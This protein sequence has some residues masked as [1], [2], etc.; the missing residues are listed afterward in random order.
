MDDVMRLISKIA[1]AVLALSGCTAGAH[2]SSP[3]EGTT[4]RLHLRD[5]KSGSPISGRVGFFRGGENL[6]FKQWKGFTGWSTQR[7]AWLDGGGEVSWTVSADS[8]II[9]PPGQ[10]RLVVNHGTEY[11]PFVEQI[12]LTEGDPQDIEVRMQRWID[13]SRMGWHSADFHLHIARFSPRHDSAL[14]DLMRSEGLDAAALVD[15]A[16]RTTGEK[17]SPHWGGWMWRRE[18]LEDAVTSPLLFMAQHWAMA[19]SACEL[20]LFGHRSPVKGRSRYSRAS[21]VRKAVN[22]GGLAIGAMGHVFVEGAI[23]GKVS[24]MEILSTGRF[25]GL[26]E[27]Y[28]LLDVGCRLAAVAGTDSQSSAKPQS[29][30]DYHGPPGANRFYVHLGRQ[31]LDTHQ[32][33]EGISKGRT[34]VTTGPALLLTVNGMIPGEEVDLEG[35][36]VVEVTV[37]LSGPLPPTGTLRIIQNGAAI[38]EAELDP[39]GRIVAEEMRFDLEQSSWIAARFDGEGRVPGGERPMAHTSPVYVRVADQPIYDEAAARELL[40]S[41]PTREAIMDSGFTNEAERAIAVEWAEAARS[42]LSAGEILG[43]HGA[44]ER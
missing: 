19:D 31:Q 35:P 25:R 27:W 11:S 1:W 18:E 40:R 36:D 39:P 13:L 41:I 6:D 3:E 44:S 4:L 2:E 14:R 32:L 7:Q 37:I 9:A 17:R 30:V 28:Q 23:L 20:G 15:W 5:A 16:G 33:L 12:E 21:L 10:V 38:W 43:H 22:E 8:E 42:R 24:A 34:F 29:I 26:D